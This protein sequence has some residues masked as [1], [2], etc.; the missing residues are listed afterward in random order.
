MAEWRLWYWLW[1]VAG[2]WGA[3]GAYVG[4]TLVIAGFLVT[5]A[6]RWHLP[7]ALRIA[8]PWW[9][10]EPLDVVY[11]YVDTDDPDWKAA[12]FVYS[13]K[14]NEPGALPDRGEVR[15]CGWQSSIWQSALKSCQGPR[16]RG[17]PATKVQY[18]ALG[19]YK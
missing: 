1:V 4:L 11:T 2:A 14:G 6:P 16:R 10:R 18:A 13:K 9:L 5:A 3:M 8:R 19:L 15:Q 12:R 17:V 7:D